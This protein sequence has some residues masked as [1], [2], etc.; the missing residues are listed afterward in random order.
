MREFPVDKK[1]LEEWKKFPLRFVGKKSRCCD[2]QTLLAQAMEGG[3]VMQYCCKCGKSDYLS[4]EEFQ[5]LY[6]WVACPGCK[7]QMKRS[8]GAKRHNYTYRCD[9]CKW[10]IKL[11]SL[12]PREADIV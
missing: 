10:E 9:D 2:T 4:E 11:A 3:F 1:T 12:V 6:L 8:K 5:K 7:V